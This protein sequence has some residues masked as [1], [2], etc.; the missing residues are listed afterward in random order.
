MNL[1][2][3]DIWMQIPGGDSEYSEKT[4][5]NSGEGPGLDRKGCATAAQR[6][7]D[8]IS[9]KQKHP[10]ERLTLHVTRTWYDIRFDPYDE[11]SVFQ[12]R[13]NVFTPTG[14]D[15]YRFLGD[16]KWGIPYVPLSLEKEVFFEEDEC[17]GGDTYQNT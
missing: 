14:K 1:R 8:A 3:L 13:K 17:E 5:R 6:I 4:A 11:R 16:M 7:V 9:Q 10:I 2:K 12:L 15:T